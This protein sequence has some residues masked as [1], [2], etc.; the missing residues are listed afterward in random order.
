MHSE[1]LN[2]PL[3]S[4]AVTIASILLSLALLLALYRSLKGPQAA[5]RVVALD[6][7]A[8]ISLSLLAL[9][10]ISSDRSVYLNVAVCIA[11]LAFLST[12]A[13]ARY[14]SRKAN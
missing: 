14:L 4:N 12:A 13:F 9:L 11:L 5:D 1:L 2:S 10:S 7:L 6:L 8:G 3:I